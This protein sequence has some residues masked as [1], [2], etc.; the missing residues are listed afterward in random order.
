MVGEGERKS[1]KEHF[2]IDL[3]CHT[4]CDFKHPNDEHRRHR[5]FHRAPLGDQNNNRHIRNINCPDILTDD[6]IHATLGSC[7]P[8]ITE[9]GSFLEA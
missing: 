2:A 3:D 5:H 1:G 7:A 8:D 6:D 9:L 4:K